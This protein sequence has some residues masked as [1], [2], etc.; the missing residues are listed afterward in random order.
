MYSSGNIM[1]FILIILMSQIT[2]KE[3][4]IQGKILILLLITIILQ[5]THKDNNMTLLL[6]TIMPQTIYKEF[7][8]LHFSVILSSSINASQESCVGTV[9]NMSTRGICLIYNQIS[10]SCE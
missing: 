3:P 2:Y 9:E 4:L 1:T 5:I 8:S 6:I 7:I 10:L